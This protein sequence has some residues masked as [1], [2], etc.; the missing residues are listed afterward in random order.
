MG[1][2]MKL[3]DCL[4]DTTLTAAERRVGSCNVPI[5]NTNYSAPNQMA[6]DSFLYYVEQKTGHRFDHV[7]KEK[8]PVNLTCPTCASVL[9]LD[10]TLSMAKCPYCG[11]TRI[12]DANRIEETQKEIAREEILEAKE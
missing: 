4:V 7:Y 11:F 2:G 1:F 12:L 10:K 8:A 6:V 9:K 5:S 3:F